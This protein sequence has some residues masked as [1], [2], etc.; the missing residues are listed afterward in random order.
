VE[1]FPPPSSVVA[2][3]CAIVVSRASQV[4]ALRF[5]LLYTVCLGI[6]RLIRYAPQR[7]LSFESMHQHCSG[8]RC[9]LRK[10]TYTKRRGRD[11]IN[12]TIGINRLQVLATRKF[13][14]MAHA[15]VRWS[16]QRTSVIPLAWVVHPKP[17]PLTLPVEG[18]CYWKRKSKLFNVSVL[19]SA[20]KAMI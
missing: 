4:S 2:E 7:S 1:L 6:I 3:S 9:P 13:F 16:D 17:L 10:L 11:V 20:G 5:F 12:I 8:S 19:A 14:T 15:L 18:R